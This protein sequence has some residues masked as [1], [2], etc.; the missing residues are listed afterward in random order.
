MATLELEC[1]NCGELLELDAGFA[2]GVCRCSSCGK[3]MSV[4]SEDSAQQPR[5]VDRPSSPGKRPDA[6]APPHSSSKPKPTPKAPVA[7]PPATKAKPPAAK[8]HHAAKANDAENQPDDQQPRPGV[9]AI[10]VGIFVA[11]MLAVVGICVVAIVMA[12]NA[13]DGVDATQ[14]AIEQFGYDPSVNPFELQQP[15]ALGL[16]LTS[17]AV[18]ILDNSSASRTWLPAVNEAVR[19]GLAGHSGRGKVGVILATEE[20]PIAMGD[21]PVSL[22]DLSQSQLE[23][24]QQQAAPTGVAPLDASLAKAITWQPAQVVLITGQW[25]TGQQVDDLR[26]QLAKRPSVK[27]DVVLIG[28][29]IPALEDLA[30]AHGGR[31]V[32]LAPRQIQ[33]WYRSA[34]E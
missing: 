20:Q 26:V 18:V 5:Q 22:S 25:L 28:E 32:Q 24:F 19:L 29:D 13:G 3:L 14:I 10:T 8:V 7:K 33:D 16:S 15:N 17:P 6:P 2:G 1:P 34:A 23:N 31:Y 30:K 4:P 27:L 9:R 12:V 11:A 21:G